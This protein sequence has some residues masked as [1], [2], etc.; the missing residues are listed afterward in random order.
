MNA[1]ENKFVFLVYFAFSIR[2]SSLEIKIMKVR[3]VPAGCYTVANS[4]PA[5]ISPVVF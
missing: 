5:L 3:I 4:I 1:F 2:R